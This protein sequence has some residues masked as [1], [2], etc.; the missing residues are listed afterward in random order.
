MGACNG[1]LP[2]F[3]LPPRT[4]DGPPDDATPEPIALDALALHWQLLVG[5]D[6]RPNGVRLSLRRRAGSAAVALSALL[7]AVVRGFQSG[8]AL[9]FPHGLVL[10]A[11]LDTVADAALARWSAPRNVLLEIGAAD[12]QDQAR[13]RLLFDSRQ[14]GVRQALRATEGLPAPERLQF[15]Q[16]VLAPAAC[17]AQVRVPVLA[18]DVHTAEQARAAFEAGAH[19]V[20]GWPMEMPPAEGRALSPSQ[21]AIFELVR[22]IQADA[23]IG[24]LERVFESEPLL[25]YL[26]LTL[27]N[28]VAFRRGAPTASLRQAVISIGYQRLIK[29]LVLMLAISAKDERSAPL[30]F[31]TLVRGYCMENLC[32]AAG[33]PRDVAEEAF[34]VGA[35]SLLD[36][37]TGQSLPSLL[38]QVGLPEDVV[39]A[40]VHGRGPYAPFLTAVRCLEGE[41]AQAHDAA[42]AALPVDGDRL[43]HA[44]LHAIAAA[45][46]LLSVI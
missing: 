15:F 4:T 26:L 16:Y 6:R 46:A 11:P 44:L 5:R 41:D 36:R 10:L 1:S 21:R 22:L 30:I 27:A 38:G 31:T 13:V 8:Q 39:D 29:W 34:V 33:G 12:L 28:S 20:V 40:L 19:G 32:Q 24:S 23:Q 42:C 7:D 3:D 25:A 37:I 14:R 18:L 9:P 35:F 43:N 17:A 45:D 2:L